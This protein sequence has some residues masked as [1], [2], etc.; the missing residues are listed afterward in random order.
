MSTRT[1]VILN[2]ENG[3]DYGE[4][5]FF[6]IL[7]DA[8]RHIEGL[9]EKG[10]ES[11]SIRLLEGCEREFVVRHRPVVS[12]LPTDDASMLVNCIEDSQV[13]PITEEDVED[14]FVA[15]AAEAW[16]DEPE[17]IPVGVSGGDRPYTK[18]GIR[19]S[20]IFARA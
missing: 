13:L 6:D 19:F 5:K 20:S 10:F 14:I 2:E 1:M 9:L 17:L 4:I 18:D 8:E 11:R 16:A 7:E 15:P 3:S 12:A